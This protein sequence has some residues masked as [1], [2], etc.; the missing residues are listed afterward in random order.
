MLINYEL[1]K[2]E[3]DPRKIICNFY[4]NLETNQENVI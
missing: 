3:V 2:T 1:G 4:I